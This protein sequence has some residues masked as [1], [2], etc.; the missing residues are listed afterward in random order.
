MKRKRD[1]D[2]MKPHELDR[3]EQ[4][5]YELRHHHDLV[6]E[7]YG[8]PFGRTL[9]A[10]EAYQELSDPVYG[11]PVD[12]LALLAELIGLYAV[13]IV[14]GDGHGIAAHVPRAEIRTTAE[15]A[16]INLN[17]EGQPVVTADVYRFTV[18]VDLSP[19]LVETAGFD[20]AAALADDVLGSLVDRVRIFRE[21]QG[22]EMSLADQVRAIE[23]SG[24][25]DVAA[26]LSG[27]GPVLS[28]G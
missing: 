24:P 3:A 2:M 8:G 21:E 7:A 6:I 22:I 14:R 17:E 12:A 4:I 9:A 20:V 27:E 5:D 26:Y 13:G 23:E 18:A 1:L 25:E 15:Q 16:T 11:D 28:G 19:D 10:I